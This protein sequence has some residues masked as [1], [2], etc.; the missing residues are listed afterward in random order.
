MRS[1]SK[2]L[3]SLTLETSKN[4]LIRNF[5]RN[6]RVR[7]KSKFFIFENLFTKNYAIKSIHYRDLMDTFPVKI[8]ENHMEIL[9]HNKVSLFI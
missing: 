9:R 3:D 8:L 7:V 1:D 6:G 4:N 2:K 5:L